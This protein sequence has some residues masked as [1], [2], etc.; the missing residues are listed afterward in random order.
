MEAAL[1]GETVR[2]VE[3]LHTM[4]VLRLLAL[5]ERAWYRAPWEGRPEID[6][7]N[8]QDWANFVNHLGY[9]ELQKLEEEGF[10]Y[11]LPLPGARSLC[12]YNKI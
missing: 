11:Y 7:S 10:E 1:W 3:H 6:H 4:V 9:R 5:A 2:A 8:Q 12:H